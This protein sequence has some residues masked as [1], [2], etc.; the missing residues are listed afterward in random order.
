[1][2]TPEQKVYCLL[3]MTINKHA[4]LQSPSSPS[5]A[6]I[7]HIKSWLLMSKLFSQ[8]LLPGSQF[9]HQDQ[10]SLSTFQTGMARSLDIQGSQ[11]HGDSPRTR[12][13]GRGDG[14]ISSAWSM[15]EVGWG[16][17]TAQYPLLYLNNILKTLRILTM[18]A[19]TVRCWTS[20]G[21]W[22]QAER[23]NSDFLWYGAARCWLPYGWW[24]EL[25]AQPQTGCRQ[26]A[27]LAALGSVWFDSSRCPSSRF[28]KQPQCSKNP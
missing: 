20:C 16:F 26:G 13:Q 11:D 5:A 18:V 8:Q 23:R 17:G 28:S 25:S 10:S 19:K 3:N 15:L 22:V 14:P 27:S 24:R 21:V 6:V 2:F 7:F 12:C 9:H 4:C 1:M